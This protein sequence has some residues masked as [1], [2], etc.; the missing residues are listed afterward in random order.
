MESQNVGR[1]FRLPRSRAGKLGLVLL[2]AL[3]MSVPLAWANDRFIDVPTASP[4]H[5]DINAIAIAGI[6]SGCNPPTN[7]FYCPGDAVR[8]DQMASFLTRGLP[9]V[10]VEQTL[11][12]SSLTRGAA[13]YTDVAEIAIN[14]GGVAGGTQFVKVDASINVFG[15]TECECRFHMRILDVTTGQIANGGFWQTTP[16][17]TSSNGTTHT[18]I[19]VFDA[20]PG[21]HLYRLQ[22]LYVS[23]VT[24]VDPQTLALTQLYMTATTYPFLSGDSDV[25]SASTPNAPT[26]K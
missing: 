14:V 13:T 17:S 9:R 26:H 12:A 3:V 2:A 16:G 23:S 7:N 1:R 5:D 4:H 24:G 22:M 21:S 20:S 8:R 19:G 11:S 6:T 10:A 18:A 15:T 25:T